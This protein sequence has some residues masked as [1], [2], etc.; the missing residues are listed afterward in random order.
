MVMTTIPMTVLPAT[1]MPVTTTV[2]VVPTIDLRRLFAR[3][4][5]KEFRVVS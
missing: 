4:F 3:N 5:A 1:V 2:K